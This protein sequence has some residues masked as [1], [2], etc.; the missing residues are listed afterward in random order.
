MTKDRSLVRA[1]DI[2]AWAYC[3]RAWWLANVKN[4]TPANV[5]ELAAGTR[6]HHVHGRTLQRSAQLLRLGYF[7]L[8]AAMILAGVALLISVLLPN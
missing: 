6:A 5:S 2:G 3:N 7:L 8:A 1:S 4:V